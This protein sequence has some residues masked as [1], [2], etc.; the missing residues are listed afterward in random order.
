[1][2]DD[3]VRVGDVILSFT[4]P[5][6]PL[7]LNDSQPQ[8]PYAARQRRGVKNL[9]KEAAYYAAIGAFPGRGP[10]MR[11]LPPSTVYVSL[12]VWGSRVR[13]P[14]NWTPTTKPIIDGLTLAGMWPDDGPEWVTEAPVSFRLV[15]KEDLMAAKVYVRL[16]PR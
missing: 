16:E 6:E 11:Q 8:S 2:G 5:G 13:D 1:M 12:P 9:W 15:S 10:S 14:G 7:T 3:R 4:R